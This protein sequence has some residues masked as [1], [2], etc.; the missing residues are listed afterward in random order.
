MKKIPFL[1]LCGALSL[2]LT[3]CTNSDVKNNVN[4][5]ESNVIGS[6]EVSG[7]LNV[8]DNTNNFYASKE[9][10]E[11]IKIKKDETIDILL[12][13]VNK[14]IRCSLY[15]FGECSYGDIKYECYRTAKF[16]FVDEMN[17]DLEEFSTANSLSVG[18]EEYEIS[19]IADVVTG[20]EYLIFKIKDQ[21]DCILSIRDDNMLCCAE[22]TLNDCAYFSYLSIHVSGERKVVPIEECYNTGIEY[23]DLYGATREYGDGV[24]HEYKDYENDDKLITA[25]RRVTIENGTIKDEPVGIYTSYGA[26]EA[27]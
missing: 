5:G 6:G 13:G 1:F 8:K 20:K 14:K 27:F 15:D 18:E 26:G 23:Y 7:E 17:N 25:L 16:T 11:W 22:Y 10:V 4:N 12:N 2:S 9:K 19:K 21:T 24:S 3:A